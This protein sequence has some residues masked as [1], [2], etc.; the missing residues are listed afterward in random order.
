M[1]AKQLKKQDK[2]TIAA[3]TPH[4]PAWTQTPDFLLKRITDAL[5]RRSPSKPHP[6]PHYPRRGL[7]K[8]K[9][10]VKH[11]SERPHFEASWDLTTVQ[12]WAL[13]SHEFKSSTLT[14]FIHHKHIHRR[15]STLPANGGCQAT[16]CSSKWKLDIQDPAALETQQGRS[17]HHQG[18]RI[19]LNQTHGSS[20]LLGKLHSTSGKHR[21]TEHKEVP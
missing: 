3:T 1:K 4:E 7:K 6:M 19:H 16:D 20:K 5:A 13:I 2:K 17:L 9:P 18:C 10:E 11:P 14:P 8:A 12:I 15:I 21:N